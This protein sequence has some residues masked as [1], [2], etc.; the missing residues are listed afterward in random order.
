[1]DMREVTSSQ[2]QSMGYDKPTRTMRVIFHNGSTYE[3]S[4]VPQD[5][6]DS[7][8]NAE[9]VGSKFSAVIKKNPKVYPYR[10]V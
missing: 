9:S 2:I 8:V 10:K 4:F 6:F 1:M 7:I 5:V 3:Y